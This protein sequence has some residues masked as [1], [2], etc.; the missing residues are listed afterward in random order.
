MKTKE[1]K[2]HRWSVQRS[3][4]DFEDVGAYYMG[5]RDGGTLAFFGP[6]G[7]NILIAYAPGS[8]KAVTYEYEEG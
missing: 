4:G 8:W 6:K 5:I 2:R 7:E 3:H 1:E